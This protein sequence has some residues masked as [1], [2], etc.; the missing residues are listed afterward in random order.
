[1]ETM[2]YA[3]VSAIKVKLLTCWER[4][5]FHSAV[6]AWHNDNWWF[7]SNQCTN[8]SEVYADTDHLMHNYDLFALF[9]GKKQ[10]ANNM[11]LSFPQF[12]SLSQHSDS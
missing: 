3:T 9:F 6:V 11:I 2:S 7:V 1:M 4:R 12:L 10:R 5:S 8:W